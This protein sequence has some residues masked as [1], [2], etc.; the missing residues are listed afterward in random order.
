MPVAQVNGIELYYERL[1]AGK[2][3]VL[4]PGLGADSK[5]FMP[6][7]TELSAGG[8]VVVLDPRGAGRSSKPREA[9]TI[10]EMAE[11]V[12]G[13][14]H[15][16]GLGPASVVGYSLGGR[17]ALCLAARHP[18]QV[19]RLVLAATSA[20]DEPSRPFGLRR[21]LIG[22]SAHLPKGRSS[23]SQPGY[24]FANQRNAAKAFDG[25]PLLGSIETPTLVIRATRDRIVPRRLSGE[26]LG[27]SGARA[28]ELAGGH[29]SMLMARHR[30]L[31]AEIV[32]FL[33]QGDR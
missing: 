8:A 16:L 5:V 25:R 23:A 26:L 28:T 6:L 10:E 11:D 33:N 32:R 9:Y 20:R 3:I 15:E 18:D 31:A 17:I 2:P 30:E 19:G 4:I 29:F 24:A 21:L 7:A 27:I 1:G 13:L 12:S 22:M 14:I